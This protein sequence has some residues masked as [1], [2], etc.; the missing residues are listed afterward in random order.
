MVIAIIAILAAILFPVLSQARLQAKVTKS[1]AQMRQLSASV[2]MYSTDN[3]DD[4]V[5][6]SMRDVA[7]NV[8]IW[9][10]G[11][12]PYVKNTEIFIAPDSAGG[13][14][15]DWNTR[16]HQS[17]GYSDATGYDPISTAQPGAAAPG[18]EGF[19]SVAN[20][21][22]MEEPS[23]VG[24]FAITANAPKDVITTKHRGYVFNPY[25][26]KNSP[27]G[28]YYKGLPMISDLD[29]VKVN[30]DKNYPNSSALSA[31]ALK[32]IFARYGADGKG[33]GRT[34]IVFG[35]G[36]CKVYSANQLNR[37]GEITWRFR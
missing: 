34:P 12:Q 23:K 3:D 13:Y 26:G 2:M 19:T 27:D 20:Q 33:A 32:P 7:G 21:S 6:A 14:A 16:R 35:D 22:T 25:N 30:N 5:P 15:A 8:Q 17:V 11:L 24:L 31:G 29:L 10:Q 18:T 1:L 4:F 28:D 9:T 36:H 37:F